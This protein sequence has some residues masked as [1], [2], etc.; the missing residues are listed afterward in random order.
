MAYTQNLNDNKKLLKLGIAIPTIVTFIA[1]WYWMVYLGKLWSYNPFT[2]VVPFIL[3]F[4]A[5]V[6]VICILESIKG[7]WTMINQ[8]LW[9]KTMGEIIVSSC[10]RSTSTTQT[11]PNNKSSALQA[12]S[13]FTPGIS[14][15]YFVGSKEYHG[16]GISGPWTEEFNT[17]LESEAVLQPYPVGKKVPV[18]YSWLHPEK[19][20]LKKI[21]PAFISLLLFVGLFFTTLSLLFG[22][23][24]TVNAC[25]GGKTPK[26]CQLFAIPPKMQPDVDRCLRKV[27]QVVE[28]HPMVKSGLIKV[29]STAQTIAGKV[30]QEKGLSIR[31]MENKLEEFNEYSEVG[32][33]DNAQRL[34]TLI[35]IFFQ[36]HYYHEAMEYSQKLIAIT[37]NDYI[38]NYNA[39][40]TLSRILAES[41]Q[42]EEAE[43]ALSKLG[44]RWGNEMKKKEF[45]LDEEFKVIHEWPQ[46]KPAKKPLPDRFWKIVAKTLDS[47]PKLKS[48]SLQGTQLVEDT[49]GKTEI[50][51]CS[52]RI[53]KSELQN[54]IMQINEELKDDENVR[55][56]HSI[57]AYREAH[58]YNEAVE[59]SKKLIEIDT[60]DFYNNWNYTNM[61]AQILAEANRTEEAEKVLRTFAEKSGNKMKESNISL[62]QAIKTLSIIP[63]GTPPRE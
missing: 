27:E 48:N 4:F 38:E 39:M 51:Y 58:Y 61:L 62:E 21:S 20:V 35:W 3:V 45:S 29:I 12:R 40:T 52:P 24:F 11:G 63:R 44:N 2:I 34:S 53:S 37:S 5:T 57:L 42:I 25:Y 26:S 32:N 60:D 33:Y 15:R 6:G 59:C 10:E 22:W 43:N 50:Q 19:A 13:I 28:S 41:G 56:I 7:C 36:G 16:T 23:G 54:K 47:P 49:K 30:F 9:P 46:Y 8:L 55:L 31:K 17:A 14:Y 18:F 1:G